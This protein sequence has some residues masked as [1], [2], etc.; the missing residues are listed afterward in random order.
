MEPMARALLKAGYGVQ[1]CDY[2]STSATIE[3]LADDVIGQALSQV[4]EGRVHFIT[5]SMGGIMVRAYLSAHDVQNLGRVVM[6][7]P[8]NSGSE[9]VDFLRGL[10]AFDW[11]NG[12]SGGQLGTD[13]Q[14]FV[15][16]L[17]PAQ[18]ELGVI[19]GNVS[20]NPVYSVMIDGESDG[21]V[22]VKATMLDGMRDHI[23]LP[24]SHTW[25]MM[26]PLV[27][28]QSI[29]FLQNGMFQPDLS[30][31]LALRSLVKTIAAR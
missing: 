11:L 30:F 9:I 22:A 13:A 24:V 19:A 26:N 6:L 8:P 7:G 31:G 27:V 20:L 23:V 2:P 14:S 1:N 12:P 18:F 25:M 3:D 29:A 15:N 4:T 5:H 10:P 17:G 16:Q 28:A 21:K